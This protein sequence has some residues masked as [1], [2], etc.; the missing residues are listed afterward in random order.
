MAEYTVQ[1]SQLDQESARWKQLKPKLESFCHQ[2][3]VDFLARG[4]NAEDISTCNKDKILGIDLFD[5]TGN[6][7]HMQKI[8]EQCQKHN[9]QMMLLCDSFVADPLHF[10][11]LQVVG[12]PELLC[13]SSSFNAPKPVIKPKQKLY[14]CFINRVEAIRQSW[15]YFLYLNNLLDKG[16]V[17]FLLYNPDLDL[18]PEELYEH[19]HN[20]SLNTL[21][22]FNKAYNDLKDLV[23]FRNFD[24]HSDL[25]P[26]L[27]KSKYTLTLDTYA[28]DDDHFAKYISEKV[29]RSLE[30]PTID[31]MFV[32]KGTLTEMSKRGFVIAQAMLDLDQLGWQQRQ[33]G[34][35]D[36]LTQDSISVTLNE[37]LDQCMHN[38]KIFKDWFDQINTIQFYEK[39]L[40]ELR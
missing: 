8:N 12:A 17:S 20:I 3:G 15:F 37:M 36:I 13:L 7:V 10:S 35:L 4:V 6:V 1:T 11:N 18:E 22:K 23:P 39:F 21:D 14:N 34:I 38:R 32:Q 28:P 24:D 29:V 30:F 19:T 25:S 33:Q 31:L 9:K 27:T 40:N 16:Y 26:Y 5:L 2:L